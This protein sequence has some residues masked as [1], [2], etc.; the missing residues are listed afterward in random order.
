[1]V[2]IQNHNEERREHFRINDSLFIQYKVIDQ[3]TA[4]QLG[5]QLINIEHGET[6]QHQVQLLSLQTAFTLVT[7]QINHYDR[8]V[9]RALRL[10][11][12]K[13]NL[14]ERSINKP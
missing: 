12:E 9:A 7:D 14:I 4:E 8:E 6:N 2:L 5:Q 1:M 13:I 3:E 10:L 11:N